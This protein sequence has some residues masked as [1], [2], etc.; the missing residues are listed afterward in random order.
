MQLYIANG[1]RQINDFHY[2]IPETKQVRRQTI[3][4]GGQILIS[5][6]LT[7]VEVDAVI[8]QHRKYGL[9][10]AD[11]IDTSNGPA[12]LCFQVGRPIPPERIS[13]LMQRNAGVMVM[14]GR[15]SRKAAAIVMANALGTSV[16]DQGTGMELSEVEVSLTEDTRGGAADEKQHEKTFVNPEN[17]PH[18]NN[19]SRGNRGRG[20]RN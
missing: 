10:P 13:L 14:R 9:I 12:P 17:K 8:D 4:V 6:D 7:K 15:E 5:G 1:T 20:Q 2:R 11:E 18:R 16:R 3:A 19:N